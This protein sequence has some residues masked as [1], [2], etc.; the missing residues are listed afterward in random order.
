[1]QVTNLKYKYIYIDKKWDT[2]DRIDTLSNVLLP[3]ILL[4]FQG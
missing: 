1:M 4:T 2:L 3:S